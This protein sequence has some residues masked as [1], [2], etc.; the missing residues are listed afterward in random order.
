[1]A[2]NYDLSM[3]EALGIKI[4]RA[5]EIEL[6]TYDIIDRFENE[7]VISK[8]ILYKEDWTANE[9]IFAFYIWGYDVGYDDCY[10]D[11]DEDD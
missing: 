7:L 8:E 3:L 4:E 9:K 2:K 10:N 5:N 11:E 1:M 6:L